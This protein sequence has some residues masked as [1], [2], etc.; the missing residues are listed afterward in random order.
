[1]LGWK[2]AEDCVSV[3]PGRM[4]RSSLGKVNPL[5]FIIVFDELEMTFYQQDQPFILDSESVC[6]MFIHPELNPEPF[7]HQT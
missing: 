7:D 2:I 6:S 5:Q 4:I 3:L 1:M